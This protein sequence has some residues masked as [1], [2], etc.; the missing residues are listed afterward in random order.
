[1]NAPGSMLLLSPAAAAATATGA[2]VFIQV[3]GAGATP[4]LVFCATP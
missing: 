3:E 1:M 4:P 2:A